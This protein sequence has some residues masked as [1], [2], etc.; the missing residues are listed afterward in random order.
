MVRLWSD[1]LGSLSDRR[2]EE[3]HHFHSAGFHFHS[4]MMMKL[5]RIRTNVTSRSSRCATHTIVTLNVFAILVHILPPLVVPVR[6]NVFTVTKPPYFRQ[7]PPSCYFKR[8]QSET[9]LSNSQRK[10]N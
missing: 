5:A 1:P 2:L 9:F 10:E 8:L 4:I 7:K 6:L 3:R